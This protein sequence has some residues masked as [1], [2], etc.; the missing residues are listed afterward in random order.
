MISEKKSQDYPRYR[1]QCHLT[2][3]GIDSSG[4]CDPKFVQLI[5]CAGR[6]KNL[7]TT[8]IDLDDNAE[9]IIEDHKKSGETKISLVNRKNK[10]DFHSRKILF[11]RHNQKNFQPQ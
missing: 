8:A 2:S 1:L 4:W 7:G 3:I 6:R 11:S 5:S 10:S 9:T